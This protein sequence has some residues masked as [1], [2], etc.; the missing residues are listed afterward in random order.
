MEFEDVCSRALVT[1]ANLLIDIV[2]NRFGISDQSKKLAK[3]VVKLLIENGIKITGWLLKKL[4]DLISKKYPSIE[5]AYTEVK[6]I[7][8]KA[9]DADECVK[10]TGFIGGVL[11]EVVT[12]IGYNCIRFCSGSIS[13]N[14]LISQT[15][16]SVNKLSA[17]PIVGAVVGAGVGVVA[18]SVAG[19]SGV[20][21]GITAGVVAGATFGSVIPVAGTI[22]GGVVGG[23]GG[24]LGG[25]IVGSVIGIAFARK[26]KKNN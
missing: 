16:Q 20:A 10:P 17:E 4:G 8:K 2:G 5:Q 12:F 6:A 18:G 21:A 25:V 1:I 3:D 14:E 23:L 19:A 13:G 24:G 15:H 7:V 26:K 11:G 22:I 9:L